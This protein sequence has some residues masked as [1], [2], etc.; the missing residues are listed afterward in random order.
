MGWWLGSRRGRAAPAAPRPSW[1]DERLKQYQ[2]LLQK[3]L[4]G[5]YLIQDQVVVY[6]N[7]RFAEIVGYPTNEIAGKLTMNMLAA[8]AAN[9]VP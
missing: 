3:S 6:A 4:A 8:D 9:H 1:K 2:A 5:V 7:P